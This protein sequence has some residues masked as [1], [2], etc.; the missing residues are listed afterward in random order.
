[1]DKIKSL[2]DSAG[3]IAWNQSFISKIVEKVNIDL[4]LPFFQNKTLM[5][6]LGGSVG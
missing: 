6:L 1:M 4:Y 5:E 2:A 3:E